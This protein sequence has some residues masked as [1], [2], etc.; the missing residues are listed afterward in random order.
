MIKV[1][2]LKEFQAA[3]REMDRDLPKQ[4]RITLNKA[5]TIVIDWAVPRIPKRTGRA[6]ASVKARSSQRE[7]RVAM[8][9]RRAPYMPWLDFGGAVGPNRSVVRPFIKRGRFLYAGLEVKHEDVT[10]IMNDG[11]ME[12]AA[13]AGL[14][15][16]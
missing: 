15:V 16:S 1:D 5:A 8:G 7:S 14:E 10:K 9:G 13:S 4:L 3:L 11:L 2:G 12:L 6:A